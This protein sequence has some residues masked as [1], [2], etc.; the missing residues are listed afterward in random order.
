MDPSQRSNEDELNQKID[1]L[2]SLNDIELYRSN[3][4][5]DFDKD[6]WRELFHSM[7]SMGSSQSNTGDEFENKG[8]MD[9]DTEQKA[10]E[11]E[12]AEKVAK[13]TADGSRGNSE[14][15]PNN[16]GPFR[17]N[18][19]DEFDNNGKMDVDT[20]K[21]ANEER[22]T[23]DVAQSKADG[24]RGKLETQS[25]G[26]T[27]ACQNW[28]WNPTKEAPESR[29]PDPTGEFEDSYWSP[30]S[31]TCTACERINS[32]RFYAERIDGEVFQGNT[33]CPNHMEDTSH[34]D[35]SKNSR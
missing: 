27:M 1:S 14:T 23:E 17:S 7:N 10:I 3:H 24:S 11:E 15:H 9:A 6:Q 26:V 28:G 29:H 18:T 32:E 35:S 30:Y 21:E 8:R 16:M 2:R 33:R 22:N 5:Y 19:G 12:H 20:E 34:Y 4:E 25:F 31:A 13:K